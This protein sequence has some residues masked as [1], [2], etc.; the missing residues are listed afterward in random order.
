VNREHPK[1]PHPDLERRP[2]RSFGWLDARLLSEG[3]LEI[4]GPE[5]VA[6]ISLLAIAADYRGASFYRRD[7]MA[8]RLSMQ[9]DALD[10]SLRRLA[11][12]G[13]VAQRPWQPGM[14]DGVWQLLPL[15]DRR[16]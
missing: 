16:P 9:R 1:P 13:L 6:V 11:E 7:T 5:A 2:P 3:W 14:I 12:L 4:L 8:L 15:P 10:R